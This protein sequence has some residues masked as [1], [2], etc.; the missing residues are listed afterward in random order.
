[1]TDTTLN[2]PP[3]PWVAQWAP[4]LVLGGTILDLA[5]G[6]GRHTHY[7]SA[8]GHP[9]VAV[10]RD[11]TA[12][13]ARNLPRG[14][15]IR[16]AD[17]EDG[18]PWPFAGQTFAG[19]VVTNYLH[20]PLLPQ[21]AAALEPGGLLIYETFA[22]GNE[23]FGSPSNPAFLLRPGELLAFAET[24]GLTVLGYFNGEASQPR[25]AVIQRLAARAP[26]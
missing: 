6:G 18:T 13:Q 14:V 10:D 11:V 17:L 21:L 4:A 7:L 25:P 1:M 23:R 19:I 12:L 24:S 2:S 26:I 5:A 16:S 20:R 3:A 9:V 22:L 8:R 15:E